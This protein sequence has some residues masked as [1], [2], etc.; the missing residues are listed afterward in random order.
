MQGLDAQIVHTLIANV[1]QEG[2]PRILI[3]TNKCKI[4]IL[5][6]KR[7]VGP[8]ALFVGKTARMI[9]IL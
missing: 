7:L 2:L 9:S 3:S 4:T 6:I 5:P 8:K 1:V